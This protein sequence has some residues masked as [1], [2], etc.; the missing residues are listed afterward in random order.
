MKKLVVS[1]VGAVALTTAGMAA[2]NHSMAASDQSF[3]SNSARGVYVSG[4]VGVGMV[5]VKKSDFN[6]PFTGAAPSKLTRYGFAWAANLGY[7]VNK[8]LAMEAGYM[9]FGKVK[10]NT[11]VA[12]TPTTVTSNFGGF[13]A[14]VKGILPVSS[15]FNL[16]GKVGAV[17]MH[18]DL[19]MS[20]AGASSR[21]H[22]S[23]WVPMVGLGTSYNLTHNVALTLEDNYAFRTNYKHSGN[24]TFM[25]ALNNVLA[26]VTYKFNV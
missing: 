4:N 20:V 22:A 2:A 24:S 16:Y 3:S 19:D 5:D 11:S 6:D 21:E 25:P 12:G 10:A 23:T 26:G 15:Q 18:D 14:A 7:Q 1:V 9:T 17:D 13:D 8:Y